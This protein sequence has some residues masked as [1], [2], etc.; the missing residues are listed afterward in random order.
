MVEG[1]SSCSIPDLI[2]LK[3]SSQV[4]PLTW[5]GQI[6]SVPHI[7]SA[8][9]SQYPGHRMLAISAQNPGKPST[10]PSG[11]SAPGHTSASR[12]SIWLTMDSSLV[13]KVAI[14]VTTALQSSQVASELAKAMVMNGN[15]VQ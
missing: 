1:S 4:M 11:S 14:A 13:V 5:L 6:S 2:P 8:S 12:M 7:H 15:K 10:Q 9:G 3:Q